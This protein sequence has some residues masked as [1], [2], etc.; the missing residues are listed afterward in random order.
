M[1]GLQATQAPAMAVPLAARQQ[2]AAA[3]AGGGRCRV[4]PGH[5]LALDLIGAAPRVGG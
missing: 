3:V 2:R 5:A 4:G 1:N